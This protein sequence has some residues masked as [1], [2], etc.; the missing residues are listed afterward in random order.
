M[1]L[2]KMFQVSIYLDKFNAHLLDLILL[3]SCYKY[4][5]PLKLVLETTAIE[6]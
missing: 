4:V 2:L 3:G 5:E 1:N 6:I